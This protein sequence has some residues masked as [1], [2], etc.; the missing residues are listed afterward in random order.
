[1]NEWWR[2][3]EVPEELTNANIASI[4]KK[5]NTEKQENYRPISLLNL[6]YKI[7]AKILKQRIEEQ[8][9]NELQST[10]YGFRKGHSTAQAIHCVRRTQEYAE[11]AWDKLNLVLLDWEKSF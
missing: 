8:V 4:Y 10:Q 5:G 6:F 7:F 3:Q 2:K 1:M 9:D 11:R